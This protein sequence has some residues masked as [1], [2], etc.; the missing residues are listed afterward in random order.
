LWPPLSA[1]A[2]ETYPYPQIAF[3]FTSTPQ[4]HSSVVSVVLT[5]SAAARSPAPSSPIPLY[6]RLPMCN[7]ER[8]LR[9]W[10]SLSATAT[11]THVHPHQQRSTSAP[12]PHS[13]VVSVVLTCSVALRSRTPAAPMLFMSRLPMCKCEHLPR[14]WVSLSLTHL[15]RAPS[16]HTNIHTQ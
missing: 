4:P 12:Q 10:G 1:T 5:C 14:S 13:S 2:A 6:E 8:W 3:I 7:C 16:S 11:A 9:T 15:H